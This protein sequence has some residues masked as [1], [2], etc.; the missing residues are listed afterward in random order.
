MKK[1][2]LLVLIMSNFCSAQSLKNI[3]SFSAGYLTGQATHEVGHYIAAWSVGV[4]I[5]PQ[6]RPEFP[7]LQYSLND[8]SLRKDGIIATGGFLAEMASSE[9]ILQYVS[10]KNTNEY[11]YFF[12]GWL[13]QTIV[14]PIS[15]SI[16]EEIN[17]AFHGDIWRISTRLNVNRY[18]VEGLLLA[19]AIITLVRAIDILNEDKIEFYSTNKSLTVKIKL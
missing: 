13:A 11:N 4:N 15:Y 17:P 12:L 1:I 9:L 16:I 6:G 2:I 7:F 18:A 5:S 14:C 10:L 8:V 3:L 19:H